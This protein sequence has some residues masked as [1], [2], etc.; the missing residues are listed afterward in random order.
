M[1][2]EA[3]CT[4]TDAD[5]AQQAL[6]AAAQGVAA[7][8]PAAIRDRYVAAAKILRLPYWD[9]ALRPPAGSTAFPGSLSATS[10]SVIDTDGQTKQI[11]NP[12][13]QFDFH[14]VNPSPGDFTATVRRAA[15]FPA[16]GV[17]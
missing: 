15:P 1:C 5:P 9:F 6:Y 8:F 16:V 2:C 3:F 4:G 14:P 17:I 7:K 13:H 10:I 12:L 11:R